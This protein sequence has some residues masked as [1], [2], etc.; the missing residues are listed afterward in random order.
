M[1]RSQIIYRLWKT[2]LLLVSGA[3]LSSGVAWA[4]SAADLTL[5]ATPEHATC[6]QDGAVTI[7]LEK[8]TGSPYNFTPSNV[9]YDLRDDKG[10]SLA[11]ASG[12]F[13]LNNRFG[14][15]KKGVYKAYAK[16][17]FD[18]GVVV[19]VGP[20]SVTVNSDY[21]IPTVAIKLERK[22]LK[23]YKENGQRVPTGII[24]VMVTGGNRPEYRVEMKKK[25]ANYTGISEHPLTPDKKIYFYNLPEGTYEFQVYDQCGGQEVQTINMEAVAFDAPQGGV[26][27]FETHPQASEETRL[28]C[29]WF[30]FRYQNRGIAQFVGADQDLQP[31]L[32]P[33]GNNLSSQGGTVVPLDT[34]AKYY[35]YGFAYGN[36]KPTNYYSSDAKPFTGSSTT[37]IAGS[38]LGMS[39]LYS[40]IVDNKKWSEAGYVDRTVKPIHNNINKDVFP[41]LFLRV[42]GSPDEMP[43][44]YRG[45]RKIT[46]TYEFAAR[47]YSL[48]DPCRTDYYINV[49]GNQELTELYCFP[50]TVGLYEDDKSTRVPGTTD[51]LL[52]RSGKS[53]N[54][55]ATILK[56]GKTYWIK[57]KDGTGS[58]VEYR[59]QLDD[60]FT[61]RADFLPSKTL[62]DI[63]TQRR[64]GQIRI[65]RD[66][67]ISAQFLNHTVTLVQAPAGYQPGE[68]GLALNEPFVFPSSYPAG[69]KPIRS[70]F[71]A[72]G[73]KSEFFM[74]DVNRDI[75]APQ[76]KY[77]YKIE[78]CDSTYYVEATINEQVRTPKWTV[79]EENF[80]P[81]LVNAS[82]GRVRIHPFTPENR[83]NFLF[84]NG[85]AEPMDLMFYI[86]EFPEGLKKEDVTHNLQPGSSWV[87]SYYEALWFGA[88]Q[89]NPEDLYFELPKTN[90]QIKIGV[91][92]FSRSNEY[93]RVFRNQ[94]CMPV[95]T[96]DLSNIPLSYERETYIGYSCPDGKTGRLFI[97]PTNNVGGVKI[98]LFYEGSSTAFATQILQ[99]DQVKNGASFDLTAPVGTTLPGKLRAKLT[100]L[101]C[102]NY[103]DESLIIYRLP[104]P[105]M[106]RTA[107]QQRKFCVGDDIE[108]AV[109]N[110]G[111]GVTYSWKLP[112]GQ[113]I[114]G[115]K[116]KL[117]NVDETYSGEYEVTIG[118]VLCGGAPSSVS[119]KFVLSVAPRELWWRKDAQNADWH[120][121]DNWA[122]R[123]GSSVR[124]VPAPCTVVHIPAQVDRAF[125]DLAGDVTNREIYGA[126][127][128]NDIYFHYGSQLGTPQQLS[129]HNAYVDYNF[130]EMGDNGVVTAYVEQGHPTAD[131]KLMD[132]NRWYMIATPLK[133]MVSGDF[134][135]GGYPKTYQRYLKMSTATPLTDASFTK[136]FNSQV[137][138]LSD[139]NHA[140]ALRV[141]GYQSGKV[142]YSDHTRLNMLDGIFRLPFF[143]APRSVSAYAHHDYDNHTETST[144]RYYNENTLA[145]TNRADTYKRTL[146]DAF[147]FVFETNNPGRRGK[148]GSI[149]VGGVNTEGYS[150]GVKPSGV[151]DD[152]IMLGNPFMTPMDFDKFY[153]V[154]QDKIQP[155][156]YLFTENTWRI[157]TKGTAGASGVAKQ[158]APLQSIVVKRKAVG[159]LLF[160]TSGDKS[161]LL[162][163]WRTGQPGRYEVKNAGVVSMVEVPLTINV[164]NREGDYSQA[165]LGWSDEVSAPVFVNS[166]YASM[167]TVFLVEPD[168]G[169]YNAITYPKRAHGTIN[170]GVASSLSS[171]LTLSFDHIDRSVYEELTLVD[172]HEG[173]EQDLLSNPQYD[174]IHKPDTTPATRFALRIK[175][176]GITN[177]TSSD[178]MPI[179]EFKMFY[180]AG[181]LRI[182]SPD[183]LHRVVVYDMQGKTL[184]DEVL[185][186][187]AT[188]TVEVDTNNAHG[189]VVVE[190]FFKNGMRTV[191]K[192]DLR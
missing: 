9:E 167:P 95:Y 183:A 165:F 173:V 187:N 114:S 180:R 36:A 168:A 13:V 72:F 133:D 83:T 70:F 139:H 17:R 123:D 11:G 189:V 85:V 25:P 150:L 41:G 29:R 175:R 130:G 23:S 185:T 19:T 94:P 57:A 135:V 53:T 146:P 8:K 52:D 131:S 113:I 43:D 101:Q 59:V 69:F 7:N 46:K 91:A 28:A 177:I 2:V 60:K 129:Y 5:T 100:D 156:Y 3:V 127:E 61:Y 1:N 161:V 138:P 89:A 115:Q 14:G 162:P 10:N 45:E 119:Q 82:C 186:D 75:F 132:R 178:E 27:P 71:Y 191:R 116:I 163:S 147:R 49:I 172:K 18:N 179:A 84:K 120:N 142:G 35:E 26:V 164:A 98:E 81:R 151:G 22:T 105:D 37:G 144:F 4:Q 125:P 190:V 47:W 149:L 12:Q 40:R 42:K 169:D 48:V 20:V 153:E 73:K 74:Q 111:E 136:P 170:L 108:L 104:S 122:K 64:G 6:I 77:V 90:G 24:S 181:S 137:E 39:Q 65:F 171:P 21:K 152:W 78:H 58:E 79:K 128:C 158:I 118:N 145:L 157:Y 16:V 141:A 88:N 56:A 32:S 92:P 80:K 103:N 51:E 106:I 66:R 68:D 30:F 33:T 110:L 134:G 87:W 107:N 76:G 155:Y 121:L 96:I 126:P 99:K 102:Q 176:F 148:I 184:A 109:I 86:A 63:C 93:D 192:Y 54:F 67:P 117:T 34:I 15:L 31:Y 160:P 38:K 97:V 62:F 143:E 140:M 50:I 44:G 112:N 182:E 174:F 154:N 188:R 166:E 124:A 159:D 55:N